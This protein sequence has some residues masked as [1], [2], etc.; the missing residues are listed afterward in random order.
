MGGK[1]SRAGVGRVTSAWPADSAPMND[2]AV[3]LGFISWCLVLTGALLAWFGAANFWL[4]T[5]EQAQSLL[6]AHWLEV[7]AGRIAVGLMF[8]GPVLILV[9]LVA[10]AQALLKKRLLISGFALPFGW[11][12]ILVWLAAAALGAWQFVRVG[13]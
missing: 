12:M 7:V 1:G 3:Q 6:Q 9:A 2:R 13:V 10:I 8:A 4:G 5:R 11:V